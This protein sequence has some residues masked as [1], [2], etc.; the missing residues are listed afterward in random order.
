ME[1]NAEPSAFFDFAASI[2]KRDGSLDARSCRDG[3]VVA[4]NNNRLA[5]ELRPRSPFH[6]FPTYSD[7]LARNDD[8]YVINAG[9]PGLTSTKATEYFPILLEED[10]MIRR[11]LKDC[12]RKNRRLRHSARQAPSE[13]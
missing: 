2:H 1:A 6:N 5:N 12:K 4:E 8:L 9:V 10:Q 7:I 11:Y 3:N 13:R